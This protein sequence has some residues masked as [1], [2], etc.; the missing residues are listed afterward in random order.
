MP[1]HSKR[2]KALRLVFFAGLFI[3]ELGLI[4]VVYFPFGGANASVDGHWEQEVPFSSAWWL[5]FAL[6]VVVAVFT[7]ANVGV[8]ITIWRAVKDLKAS[9]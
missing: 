8:L 6:V 9:D 1:A 5:P 7:M 3:I 2:A 4:A